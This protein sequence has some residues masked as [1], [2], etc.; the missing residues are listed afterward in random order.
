MV[1]V[2]SVL[3]ARC[4]LRFYFSIEHTFA[5]LLNF[6]DCHFEIGCYDY[7]ELAY[8]LHGSSLNKFL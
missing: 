8:I 5:V 2:N 6:C 3:S 7:V 4:W 1:K